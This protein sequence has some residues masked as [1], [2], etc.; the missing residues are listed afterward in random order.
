VTKSV[1][2]NRVKVTIDADKHIADVLL[3]RADKMNAVDLAMFEALGEAADRIASDPSIRAVVL[4]GAGEN[5]CAGIDLS[6]LANSDFD[7]DQALK[8]PLVPSAA[9]L[10]QRAAYAWRE[11]PIP[12]I[13][14]IEGVTFGA[15][16][17]IAL[18]ADLRFA[19][20]GATFSIMES[21]WGI[22]PDMGLAATLRDLVAPDRV[23]ELSWSARVFGS[24][25]AEA[26]GL[27]TAITD[28]PLGKAREFATDCSAK[29]PDAIRGIKALVNEAWQ[30]TEREALALEAHLQSDII[31]GE[32]QQEAV[33]AN[34]AKRKPRFR[35]RDP[36][37]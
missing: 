3:N 5:F 21:K 37:L 34:I 22:I 31:G 9:N 15:G 1:Q 14:A 20:P 35:D 25:E 17:Q 2:N 6:I 23:K 10:F 26:L 4:H 12:V 18:G 7:F 16:M 8:T 36:E 32:N 11:L 28:D 24:S 29:S 13:C 30:I 19:S 33:A 27:I